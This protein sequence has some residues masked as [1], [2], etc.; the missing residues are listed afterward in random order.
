MQKMTVSVFAM[1]HGDDEAM[2][3]TETWEAETREELG[4]RYV[5]FLRSTADEI[6]EALKLEGA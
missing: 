1:L 6:E 3:M 4:S 2:S 5:A